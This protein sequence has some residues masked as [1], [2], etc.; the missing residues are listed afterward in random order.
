MTVPIIDYDLRL[1]R[2]PSHVG[3]L[4]VESEVPRL[5]YER[6]AN[7][8]WATI[9]YLERNL[10]R[11]NVQRAASERHMRRLYNMVLLSLVEAFERFIK[12]IAAACVDQICRLVLD[13][14]LDV[15]TLKGDDL[16][17][18]FDA[19]TIGKSLCESSTWLDCD[20]INKR[21]K[22]ILKD[23]FKDGT[24]DLFPKGSSRRRLVEIVFQLRHS[25]VHNAS[26]ITKSDALKFQLLTRGAVDAPR[27]LRPTRGDVW[28]VKLFLDKTVK[29]ID[30]EIGD[31]LSAL[32]STLWADD[33]HSLDP[34]ERAELLAN[35]F[36]RPFRVGYEIRLP[37]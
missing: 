37:S 12:E 20:Q 15:F 22:K 6:S 27:A 34:G 13:D 32:L 14:R 5:H 31:R 16:A 7:D 23:P 8:S 9:V 33:P 30:R 18:H 25:I 4:P 17:A 10:E 21:F 36:R 26:L 19:G 24:F 1:S 29:D 35:L 2:I 3:P 11:V 28:Y